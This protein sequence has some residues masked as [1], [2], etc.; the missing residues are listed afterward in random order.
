MNK[1]YLSIALLFAFASGAQAQDVTAGMTMDGMDMKE[2]QS[3]PAAHA[4]GTVKAIDAQGG[5]VTLMHGPVAAL[6]WP[7]MTMGFKASAQQLDD[8]KVGDKV[9]FDF[10]MEGSTARIVDIRKN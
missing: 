7:A 1:R 8:L 6:K 3:S 2:A 10:R 9:A 4:E 5:K